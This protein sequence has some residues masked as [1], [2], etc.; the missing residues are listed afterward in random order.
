[1]IELCNLSSTMYLW[2]CVCVSNVG[3]YV[4]RNH[5][6]SSS[7]QFVYIFYGVGR[8]FICLFFL[9]VCYYYFQIRLYPYCSTST[10]DMETFF[11][12]KWKLCVYSWWIEKSIFTLNLAT[13][14][15]RYCQIVFFSVS[16]L[17]ILSCCY[18]DVIKVW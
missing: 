16:C 10:W 1:M 8:V 2:V 13:I 15:A 12:M 18:I 4:R 11:C 3:M 9:I 6:L 17:F 7:R 14:F 5:S